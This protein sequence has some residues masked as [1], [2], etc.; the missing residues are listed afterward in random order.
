MA[1][2]GYAYLSLWQSIDL[3]NA[4]ITEMTSRV[5]KNRLRELMRRVATSGQEETRVVI[6]GFFH[7]LLHDQSFWLGKHQ[8]SSQFNPR[9]VLEERFPTCFY[10]H[11]VTVFSPSP[12]SNPTKHATSTSLFRKN[13]LGIFWTISTLV[14]SL[15]EQ[16]LFWAC[17]SP[18]S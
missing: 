2:Y 5:L 17:V 9:R 12:P 16:I 8:D 7:S 4:A 3:D 18:K 11:E 6:A 13:Q 1:A 10:E 15:N 14:Q